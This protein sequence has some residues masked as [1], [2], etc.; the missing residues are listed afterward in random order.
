MWKYTWDI[1]PSDGWSPPST[2]PIG[3]DV[4]VILA[5]STVRGVLVT[6]PQ[7]SRM[8]FHRFGWSR[9]GESTVEHQ[10]LGSPEILLLSLALRVCHHGEKRYDVID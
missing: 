7:S 6:R 10:P 2:I 4:V 9:M 3:I 8:F 1:Y 5:G